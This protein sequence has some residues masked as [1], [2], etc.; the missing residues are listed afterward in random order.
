M[1]GNL[2]SFLSFATFAEW[3][4]SVLRFNLHAAIP[5][6]LRPNS[7]APKNCIYLLGSIST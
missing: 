7:S 3:R 4:E 5:L 6:I 2:S 1:P